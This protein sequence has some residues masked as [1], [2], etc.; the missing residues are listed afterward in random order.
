MTPQT[1]NARPSGGQKK[2]TATRSNN[3][4]RTSRSKPRGSSTKAKSSSTKSRAPARRAN[5]NGN[6]GIAGK[7]T[8]TLSKA[9]GPAV[10]GAATAAGLVGGAVIGSRFGRKPKRVLGIPIPGTGRGADGLAKEVRKAGKQ[11]G[12]LAEE[13]RVTRKKAEDVGGAL[14]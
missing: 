8:G 11:F 7:V 5:V 4:R 12:E 10:T 13:I 14:K 6:S 1:S 3:G 9:K 2:S